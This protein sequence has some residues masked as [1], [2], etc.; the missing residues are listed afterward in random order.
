M[1][2][3]KW[4]IALQG[5]Q[6]REERIAAVGTIKPGHLV[7]P[8][9]STVNNIALAGAATALVE[10]ALEDVLQGGTIADAYASGAKV[11]TAKPKAGDVVL[12]R[13]TAA[14]YAE[15]TLLKTAANGILVAVAAATDR[16]VAAAE[17]LDTNDQPVVSKVIAADGD[18]MRVRIL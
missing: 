16:A 12:A 2:T 14:T 15:G 11:F 7:V 1:P 13:M 3:N 8:N 6:V 17:P 18:L 10:I 5:C 9:G 4:T